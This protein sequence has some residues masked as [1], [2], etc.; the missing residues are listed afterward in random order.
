MRV[1]WFANTT[2]APISGR[3]SYN[4]VGW[5]ASLQHELMKRG[6]V[7]LGVAMI[8]SDTSKV[9]QDGVVYY[10]VKR[11][12]KSLAERLLS[13]LQPS[14]M[15]YEQRRWPYYEAEFLK[16]IEDFCPDVIQIFGTEFYYGLIGGRT[17]VP[18][19]IHIQGVLNSCLNAFLP[20]GASPL[21]YYFQNW[22][23]HEIWSR[24]QI[25]SEWKRECH[26]EREIFRRVKYYIGRTDWD[27]ACV[28]VYNPEAHYL[29]G[30][31]ILREVFYDEPCRQVPPRPVISTTISAA[32]YKGLDNV[33]KAAK[34]LKAIMGNGFIWN[35]Y[36][37]INPTFAERLTGI[38]CKDVNICMC[39]VVSAEQLRK[40]LDE[41]TVYYHSS[42]IENTSNAIGEAQMRQCPV[43]ANYVGGVT[44]NVHQGA[45][46]FLVPVN[47]PY[48]TAYRIWQLI[49][50][51][52]LADEMGRRGREWAMER[53]NKD[54]IVEELLKTYQTLIAAN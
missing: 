50:N 25:Y 41:S 27:K 42:Y 24:F 5:I 51:Q 39:G 18:V 32:M 38:K 19:V 54:K 3:H 33:L 45:E 23:P 44:S 14:N 2:M 11:R 37:N 52:V 13:G 12:Q 7:E 35:V 48:T 28:K 21:T 30:E 46:G 29:F 47:D 1:L 20:V 4:G 15:K 17:E 49:N 26:R 31:E 6:D 40:S 43:V 8:A 22:K 34:C 36:G 9:S 10:F 53:H 16:I